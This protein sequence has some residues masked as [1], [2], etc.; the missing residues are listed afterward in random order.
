MN[1]DLQFLYAK[2]GFFL[3]WVIHYGISG[4]IALVSI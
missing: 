1:L 4:I 2:L 3:F